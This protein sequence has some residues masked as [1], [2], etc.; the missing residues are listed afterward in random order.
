VC[1][2][3]CPVGTCPVCKEEYFWPEAAR[4]CSHT[5]PRR[6]HLKWITEIENTKD[7]EF[8]IHA[9]MRN[10]E[11]RC[12]D[13][14]ER[15]ELGERV[16]YET[17]MYNFYSKQTEQTWKMYCIPKVMQYYRDHDV[18]VNKDNPWLEGIWDDR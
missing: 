11:D 13:L 9:E 2:E 3:R 7:L 12:N 1:Y 16:E 15:I 5:E 4:N 18:P 10:R 17:M 6:N 14:I 8:W